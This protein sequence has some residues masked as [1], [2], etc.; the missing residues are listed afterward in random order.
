[1]IKNCP[2]KGSYL[3]MYSLLFE[4]NYTYQS[5]FQVHKVGNVGI[6]GLHRG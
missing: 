5:F 4:K 6:K 2:F 1:M 3:Y